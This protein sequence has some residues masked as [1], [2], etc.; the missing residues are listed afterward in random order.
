MIKA[1]IAGLWFCAVTLGAVYYALNWQL[2]QSQ[3]EGHDKEHAALESKKPRLLSVPVIQ[4]G[5]VQ[6]YIV[7]QFVFVIDVRLVKHLTVPLDVFL[8]DEGIKAIYGGDIPDYHKIKRQDLVAMTKLIGENINKRFG[9]PLVQDVLLQELSYLPKE[10][11][12]GGA[13]Q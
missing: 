4:D 7:A 2:G 3:G 11:A 1:L 9:A 5:A 10:K 13:Q 12:R 6:G 8:V